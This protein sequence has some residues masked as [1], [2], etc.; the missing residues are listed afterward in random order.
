MA[1]NNSSK[2]SNN[3]NGSQIQLKNVKLD[4]KKLEWSL[5]PIIFQDKDNKPILEIRD[6]NTFFVRRQQTDSDEK[7][8][9]A[10]RE[11]TNIHD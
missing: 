6:S 11:W 2:K 5:F 3:I 1:D 10:L 9:K 7:I 8:G 4:T